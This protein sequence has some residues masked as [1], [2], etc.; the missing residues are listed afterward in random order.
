MLLRT[1]SSTPAWS[2]FFCELSQQQCHSEILGNTL[3]VIT[4]ESLGLG[5]GH[6]LGC[7]HLHLL[8]SKGA[9]TDH[10]SKIDAGCHPEQYTV[11]L[12]MGVHGK[13]HK[14]WFD[15]SLKNALLLLALFCCITHVSITPRSLCFCLFNLSSIIC[16][17][18]IGDSLLH[19][20][21]NT[22]SFE[23]ID[24]LVTE[25]GLNVN[26]GNVVSAP[27]SIIAIA[28]VHAKMNK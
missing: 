21:I 22:G 13:Y 16:L 19:V 25:H 10:V 5:N 18:Q 3:P 24:Y 7:L 1:H 27:L 9:S 6:T 23:I 12:H 26:E 4:S 14:A 11:V 8:R 20:A 28:I 15:Y 17:L 2:V